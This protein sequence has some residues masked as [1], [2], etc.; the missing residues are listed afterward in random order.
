MLENDILVDRK[1]SRPE[2]SGHKITL[3]EELKKSHKMRLII[4]NHSKREI[5]NNFERCS[6][7]CSDSLHKIINANSKHVVQ[8]NCYML[9]NGIALR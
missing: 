5:Q 8:F 9:E 6:S 2:R 3:T 4:L 7:Y 1:F